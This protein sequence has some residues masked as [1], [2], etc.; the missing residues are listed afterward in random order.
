MTDNHWQLQEAKNKLSE[1][2]R[3]AQESPQYITVHG[4]PAVVVVSVRQYE[5]MTRPRTSLLEFFQTSPLRAAE[6]D[7]MRPGDPPRDVDL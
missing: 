2:V 5:A 3:L 7:W 6:L 4:R 1:V